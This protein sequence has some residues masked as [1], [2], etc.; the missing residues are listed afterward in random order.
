MT[1]PFNSEKFA[2]SCFSFPPLSFSFL[3]CKRTNMKNTRESNKP[4]PFPFTPSPEQKESQTE[5][6]KK[7]MKTCYFFPT[8]IEL[9][10]FRMMSISETPKQFCPLV[11]SGAG[12]VGLSSFI[13]PPRLHCTGINTQW[14]THC[15]QKKTDDDRD[16][17][18]VAPEV[19]WYICRSSFMLLHILIVPKIYTHVGTHSTDACAHTRHRNCV[20]LW[21]R[22][23]LQSGVKR[24]SSQNRAFC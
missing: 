20:F 6:L 9:Q 3:P 1:F 21:H 10:Q 7:K 24:P 8:K 5:S 2:E 13:H 18:R 15:W 23:C 17:E 19:W 12:H 16:A 14:S 11:L 22:R 4:L